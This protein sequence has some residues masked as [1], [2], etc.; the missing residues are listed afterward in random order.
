MSVLL[1][2]ASP[3]VR[4]RSGALLAGAAERL[5]HLGLAP[6]TLKLRDLPAQPL[7]HA[8][9]DHPEILASLEAVAQ[10]K[11]VVLATP[12]YKAAYSGLLKVFLDLLP[13]DGLMG[14]SVWTLATGGSL[15]HLLALDYGLLPV[16]SALG[17]RAHVDGVYATD[18][19]IPREPDGDYR[20]DDEITRRLAIGASQVFERVPHPALEASQA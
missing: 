18:A 13:Q 5:Q 12:I 6:R 3:S 19:H 1:I 10:A 8:E 9:F 17:A 20:I 7:L 14:K 4:S 2:A 16:L 15:A 11:V